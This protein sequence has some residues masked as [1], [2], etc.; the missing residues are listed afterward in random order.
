MKST[1]RENPMDPQTVHRL[2][3]DIE[4]AIAEVMMRMG[5]ER[6]PLVPSQRTMPPMAKAAVAV[7]AAVANEQH[8]R[9]RDHHEQRPEP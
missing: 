6:L 8:G 2:E 7:L 3:D 5:L 4:Q 9:Q 1:A